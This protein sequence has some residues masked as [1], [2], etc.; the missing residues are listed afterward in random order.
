MA[1]AA[2][3]RKKTDA[4][5]GKKRPGASAR[6][7]GNRAPA[8][9]QRPPGPGN[10]I[11]EGPPRTRGMGHGGHRL[12]EAFGA[13]ERLPVLAELQRRLRSLLG[14]PA[15]SE[16]EVTDAIEADVALVI[17]VMRAASDR[18]SEP[19]RVWGVA[20][21]VSV[22]GPAGVAYAAEEVDAYELFEPPAEWQGQLEPLRRHSVA[23]R[24]ATVRIAELGGHANWD[25]LG[26][27][28][29]LHDVGTLVL[30]RLYPG[31][32]EL[33][34]HRSGTPEGRIQAERRE[35]G[36]DHALVGGVLTRR[37]GL[38]PSVT[39]TVERHHGADPEGPAAVVALADQI[40]HHGH[41]DP[42]APE[43]LTALAYRA[44]IDP[45][46]LTGLLVELPPAQPPRRRVPEPC[47]LSPREL[48][49]L[50]GLAQG[51]VYREIA[52]DLSL[53]ASTV[54]THLHNV[55]RKLGAIDRAQAV[56]IARDRGWI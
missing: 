6:K 34:A 21:A 18:G 47:P 44:G 42:V 26:L 5:R 27:A 2:Q 46:R 40:A 48:D 13:V 39:Q 29:M 56:L 33:V 8:R 38:P 49:A 20:D 51:K 43:R 52:D 37:W 28:A 53:S 3:T 11:P 1:R 12:A 22:L 10:S 36:I 24:Y 23:T 15:G 31:Y 30:A 25:E 45:D 9:K 4:R 54:R 50:R 14:K 35:L 41:G 55:Y 16:A 7:N 19:G 17:A 32:Q